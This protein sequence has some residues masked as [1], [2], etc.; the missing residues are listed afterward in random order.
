MY[1]HI[2][3]HAGVTI[4]C[5]KVA[6]GFTARLGNLAQL[7]SLWVMTDILRRYFLWYCFSRVAY[8]PGYSR[9]LYF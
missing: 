9:N 1:S 4:I 2:M 6:A 8:R 3:K 5:F 7:V